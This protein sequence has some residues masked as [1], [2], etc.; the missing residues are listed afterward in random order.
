MLA[1]LAVHSAVSQNTAEKDGFNPRIYYGDDAEKGEFPFMVRCVEYSGI[2]IMCFVGVTFGSQNHQLNHL[3][4]TDLKVLNH[5]ASS[6]F[7]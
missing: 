5:L 7:Y 2:F 1:L 6:E 3:P 4:P